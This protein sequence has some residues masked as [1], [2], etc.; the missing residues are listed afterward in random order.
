MKNNN[1]YDT[2]LKSMY[3]LKRF[4]IKLGLDLI[5]N[6]LEG[7]GNPQNNYKCIHV[8]GSNGKGSIASSLSTILNLAGYKTGLYTSPHLVR[9][10]ERICIN[11]SEI[12]DK[13][14]VDSYKAVKKVHYGEREPT[15]FEFAT[16]MALYEF[17]GKKVDWAI[18]ETGM[19]GRLDA[20]NIINPSLSIISNICIEHKM[21]LGNT[22]ADIAGEKGGIIKSKAPIITGA[23]Q[24]NA[25]LV[26]K[27]LAKQKN[28]P[29]YR[30][31][32]DFRI[33]RNKTGTFT[34]FGI[35]NNVLQNMKTR[36]YGRHQ[37]D[38]AA[39]S[40]AASEILNQNDAKIPIECIK[41]G[42]EKN[43]WRGR[44]EVVSKSP[45]IIIDG[46]HNLAASKNLANF[47]VKNEETVGK[48]ITL[49][50]GILD[51]KPYKA[52]L[53]AL[54]PVCSRTILTQPA[55]DRSLPVEKLLPEAK[56]NAKNNKTVE[57]T[58]SVDKAVKLAIDTSKKDEVICI[59]GSLYV[60]G[61]AISTLRPLPRG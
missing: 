23:K 49:I 25:I 3:S 48:K 13:E 56:K 9:F 59:A 45:F 34:Y 58:Q 33:R 18:I 16:A 21:Y 41:E 10:N 57:I 53:K 52:M 24:K 6:I 42:L 37:Q 12:S 46:A 38:N 60:V 50:I 19:G 44:L 51:D 8:A 26:F 20:T 17:G 30:Y 35:N 4:G 5:S 55:S 40:I 29:F 36:L 32:K 47:L 43:I 7:L 54:I 11:N 39:I 22:I 1:S 15:F 27:K 14:V 28:A 31:G 61:E 2:C